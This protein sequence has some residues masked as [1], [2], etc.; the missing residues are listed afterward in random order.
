MRIYKRQSCYKL[1]L[2]LSGTCRTHFGCQVLN[3][4]GVNPGTDSVFM[5]FWRFL[6]TFDVFWTIS[7]KLGHFYEGI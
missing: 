4:E 1:V 7:S 2:A 3:I 5:R 6:A